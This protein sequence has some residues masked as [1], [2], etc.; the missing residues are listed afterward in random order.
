MRNPRMVER[1][2]KAM[3]VKASP[4]VKKIVSVW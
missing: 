4:V 1:N 3:S 2:V